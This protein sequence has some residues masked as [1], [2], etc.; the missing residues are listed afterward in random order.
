[1]SEQ[2]IHLAPGISYSPSALIQ[3]FNSALTPTPMKNMIQLKGIYQ[4]GRGANY[5]G[6][7]YDGLK[8]EATDATLT[9]VVPALLRK[10][11]APNKTIEFWAFITKRVVPA[12]GRIEIHANITQLLAQTQNRYNEKEIRGLAIQQEKASRGYRDV[13]HF[14]K[15]RIVQQER[16]RITIL[17][18]KAAIIDSDIRHGMEEAIGFYDI[19]FERI[20]MNSE[21]EIVD[22][23]DRFND[24]GMTDLLVLSRGGGE[25]LEIFDSPVIA[26]RCLNLEPYFLTAIGHKENTSLV[27]RVADKAFITPTALGQWLRSIYN[28]TMAELENSKARLV[29][30]ITQQLKTGYEKEV[31]NL[32]DRI[33]TMEELGGKGQALRQQE[34]AV[35]KELMEEY[36]SQIRRLETETGKGGLIKWAVWIAI[37]A[38]AALLGWLLGKKI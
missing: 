32:N 5:N 13:D 15:S 35:L 6:Y 7:Y 23:L 8:D 2:P 1:M 18:G 10:D 36:K 30:T 21:T 34:L 16:I 22:A 25:N 26:E 37:A 27:Q 31:Q 38:V 19:G 9:L 14:I 11:L 33:R 12:G 17:V 24:T 29:E 20:S 3:L 28:D 4:P